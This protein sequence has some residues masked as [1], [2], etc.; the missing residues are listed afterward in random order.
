MW[1][2]LNSGAVTSAEEWEKPAKHRK[3]PQVELR[4]PVVPGMG[5]QSTGSQASTSQSINSDPTTI[6]GVP[7]P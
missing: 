7:K 4:D 2:P 6:D 3:E 1:R 5:P